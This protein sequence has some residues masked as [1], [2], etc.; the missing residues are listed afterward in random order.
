MYKFQLNIK[1]I[2]YKKIIFRYY[3]INAT[4]KK[5]R[6]IYENADKFLISNWWCN[7]L[8]FTEIYLHQIA[9]FADEFSS[10]NR[11]L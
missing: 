8:K 5:C 11:F 6:G 4:N 1:G 10:A 7:I 9:R 2:H 3:T